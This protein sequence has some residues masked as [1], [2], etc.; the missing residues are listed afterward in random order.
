MREKGL[1]TDQGG[2]T[3]VEVILGILLL[4]V[5]S[6]VLAG[7]FSAGYEGVFAAVGRYRENIQL[8]H[9]DRAFKAELLRVRPPYFE[10]EVL[11]EEKEGSGFPGGLVFGWYDGVEDSVLAMTVVGE[12]TD[13]GNPSLLVAESIAAGAPGEIERGVSSR[14]LRLPEGWSGDL[15]YDEEEGLVYLRLRGSGDEERVISSTLG[16]RPLG[17]AMGD[18]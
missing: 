17:P 12:D 5:V 4:T 9:I 2:Y 7:S 1:L 16:G 13:E 10:R 18:W 14:A 3:F 15:R 8:L 6:A 11:S